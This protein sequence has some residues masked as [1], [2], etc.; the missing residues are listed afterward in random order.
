MCGSRTD[1]AIPPSTRNIAASI[2]N[3]RVKLPGRLASTIWPPAS[4]PMP[5]AR[6]C[7]KNCIA[8]ARVR[9]DGLEHQTI[10]VA[11]AGCITAVPA[12]S[13]AADRTTVETPADSPMLMEPAAASTAAP[14][15]T[16]SG[17]RRSIT[18]P[19]KGRT[20][21]AATAKTASTT[22]AVLEPRSRTWDT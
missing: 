9:V 20:T 5:S 22:P 13:N 21:S 11:S 3:S 18:R 6:F 16:G 19:V 12:P 8:K 4:P 1:A 14:T 2:P 15:S 17:P 10:I 7:R